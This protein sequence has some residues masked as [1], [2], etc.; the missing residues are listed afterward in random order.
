MSLKPMLLR[1]FSTLITAFRHDLLWFFRL[2]D[3]NSSLGQL[4]YHGVVPRRNAGPVGCESSTLPPAVRCEEEDRDGLWWLP[5]R[6]KISTLQRSAGTCCASDGV[7]SLCESVP[8]ST[9]NNNKSKKN[10]AR[11][12]RSVQRQ[13]ELARKLEGELS[14]LINLEKRLSRV[15]PNPSRPGRGRVAAVAAGLHPIAKKLFHGLTNPN[16]TVGVYMPTHDAQSSMKFKARYRFAMDIPASG[17]AALFPTP[18]LS[19]E[20]DS[21]MTGIL[22]SGNWWES[23]G[24]FRTSAFTTYTRHVFGTLPFSASQISDGISGK[25]ISYTIRVKYSGTHLYRAGLGISYENP[26]RPLLSGNGGVTDTSA[27]NTYMPECVNNPHYARYCNF[28][29]EPEHEFI[30]HPALWKS[31][32]SGPANTWIAGAGDYTTTEFPAYPNVETILFANTGKATGCP[33]GFLILDNNSSN[34]LSFIIE[35]SA[36]YEFTGTHAMPF[37]TPSPA[38]PVDAVNRVIQCV[39][40]AKREHVNDPHSSLQKVTSGLLKRGAAAALQVAREGLSQQAESKA[41]TNMS[42]AAGIAGMLL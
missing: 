23:G 20:C 34:A 37:A 32:G 9:S 3:S 10:P 38:G 40:Q 26:D 22:N 28:S 16:E 2:L 8:K 41:G 17:T 27:F 1:G 35:V 39:R 31:E 11:L 14:R 12:Q 30:F 7:R 15:A 13:R 18:A 5:T 4:I 25:C 33:N 42:I 36:D 21:L 6:Y 24:N 29:Q 19:N